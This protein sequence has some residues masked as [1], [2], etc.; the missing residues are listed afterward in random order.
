MCCAHTTRRKHSGSADDLRL[1]AAFGTTLRVGTRERHY[2]FWLTVITGGVDYTSDGK[3]DI[4]ARSSAG[5]FWVYR[6]TGTG[7]V[8]PANLE[9]PSR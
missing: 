2:M 4:L 3:A 7:F 9:T 8:G 5:E 6:G 1:E